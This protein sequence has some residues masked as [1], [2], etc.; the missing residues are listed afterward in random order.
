LS[1]FGATAVRTIGSILIILVGLVWEFSAEIHTFIDQIANQKLQA[2]LAAHISQIGP[3]ALIGGGIFWIVSLHAW[4]ALRRWLRPSPLAIIYKPQ[5]HASVRHRNMRDYHIELRNCATDQTI[6]DVIVTWD[7]TPFTRFIDKTFS[8][9]WLLSPTSIGPS[10]SASIFLFSLKDDL[11]IVENKN[12]V[13]GRASTFT[14]RASGKGIDDL[15]AR[16]RYEPDKVPKL[17]MLWR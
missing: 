15:T 17:R 7:E 12:D 3:L 16:F 10:S 5:V 8:R 6:S 14:V 9:D 11:R 2:W 4:P 13:L 1:T